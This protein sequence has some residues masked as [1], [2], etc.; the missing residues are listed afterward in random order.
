M[1]GPGIVGQRPVLEPGQSFHDTSGRLLTSLYGT[2]RGRYEMVT[3]DGERFDEKIALFPLR[4]PDTV[5]RRAAAGRSGA[6]PDAS[7]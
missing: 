6:V 2:I 5:H 1:R 3:A 4:R 7:P